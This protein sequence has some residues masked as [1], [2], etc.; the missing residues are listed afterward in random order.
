MKTNELPDLFEPGYYQLSNEEIIKITYD[1]GKPRFP[2]YPRKIYGEN[3]QEV[4]T[5]EAKI[6]KFRGACQIDYHPTLE[7]IWEL[8][9][10]SPMK[11]HPHATREIKPDDDIVWM[12]RYQVLFSKAIEFGHLQ[13]RTKGYYRENEERNY[14]PIKNSIIHKLSETFWM[15]RNPNQEKEIQTLE[16][17]GIWAK[18][19]T[20][21]NAETLIKTISPRNK[22][23]VF[24]CS[25]QC[26]VTGQTF[27][28][29]FNGKTVEAIQQFLTHEETEDKKISLG[30]ELK[31]LR[32]EKNPSEE[33]TERTK[34]LAVV[35]ETPNGW[36][37]GYETLHLKPIIP[38]QEAW[39]DPKTNKFPKAVVTIDVPT[40]ELVFANSLLQYLKDIPDE[41]EFDAEYDVGTTR[42]KNGLIKFHAEVNQAF[43]VP[44]SNC[45]PEIWQN[46]TE[47][48]KLRV[49]K[50][51]EEAKLG[52]W[53]YK[54]AKKDWE[55]RGS[56][57]T[58]LWAFHAC[59]KSRL[60]K[61]IK[62]DHFTVQIPPG[63]YQLTNHY[64]HKESQNGIYCEIERI[65]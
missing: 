44:L 41:N 40:G 25:C 13:I 23:V 3:T 29:G 63:R 21:E 12:D 22:K 27:T 15:S 65:G 7:E 54:D 62:V 10:T 6:E 51:N 46:K 20:K 1:T 60:P 64:E 61:K 36:I 33:Q 59:D 5:D 31:T 2:Q 26:P 35:L 50:T 28:W 43:F 57:C 9:K 11:P 30:E 45:S 58:D 19:P 53:S 8:A 38:F 52:Q 39:A 34:F 55:E 17:I 32:A 18:E 14:E 49:G 37:K 16:A 24:N 4:K 48:H 42:G 56:V 47:P